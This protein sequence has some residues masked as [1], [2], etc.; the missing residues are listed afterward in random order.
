MDWICYLPGFLRHKDS[1]K[2]DVC[3]DLFIFIS[4]LFPNFY[5]FIPSVCDCWRIHLRDVNYMVLPWIL[6]CFNKWRFDFFSKFSICTFGNYLWNFICWGTWDWLPFGRWALSILDSISSED[7][8]GIT[9]CISF[10]RILLVVSQ[11]SLNDSCLIF[12]KMRVFLRLW[13]LVSSRSSC[14]IFKWFSRSTIF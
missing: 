2:F 6:Y 10:A 4:Q 14:R 13:F 5:G 8:W 9:I 1:R 7:L 12:R 11:D 3:L